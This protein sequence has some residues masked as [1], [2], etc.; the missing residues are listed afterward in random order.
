[1]FWK[2]HELAN[3]NNIVSDEE[4]RFQTL[5]LF[6][7]IEEKTWTETNLHLNVLRTH[8][9]DKEEQADD[10]PKKKHAVYKPND[11]KRITNYS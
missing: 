3:V 1:M 6:W 2:A 5:F 10:T 4:N 7:S 9:H 11:A 8:E